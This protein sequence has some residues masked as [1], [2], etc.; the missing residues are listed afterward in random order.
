LKSRAASG[1]TPLISDNINGRQNELATN[2][3]RGLVALNGSLR[4][5]RFDEE[6]PSRSSKQVMT[7]MG[8]KAE[9]SALQE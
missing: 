6:S 3:Q 4:V 9:K 2:F 5:K 1:G 8:E 7:K